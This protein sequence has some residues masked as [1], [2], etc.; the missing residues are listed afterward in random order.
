MSLKVNIFQNTAAM[1]SPS[2]GVNAYMMMV[3][4]LVHGFTRMPSQS[5]LPGSS[6]TKLPSTLNIDVGICTEQISITG[7]V[8]DI[9]TTVGIPAKTDI[10][11]IMRTWWDYGGTPSKLPIIQEASGE[12]YCGNFKTCN[13]TQQGGEEITWIVEL[14][15]VVEAKC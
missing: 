9:S 15:F 5:G 13:L 8:P 4:N 1:N 14:V 7:V 3:Q 6:L 10:D 11:T 12:Q 2:W